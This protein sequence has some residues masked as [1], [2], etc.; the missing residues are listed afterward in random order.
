M[1]HADQEHAVQLRLS[2]LIPQL[3]DLC[4]CD[5][6]GLK[7]R[8]ALHVCLAASNK[9][10]P[11]FL[12]TL[13]KAGMIRRFTK[14][15][16]MP[17]ATSSA[18]DAQCMACAFYLLRLTLRRTLNDTLPTV[19]DE[20]FTYGHMG[21]VAAALNNHSHENFEIVM[22]VVANLLHCV[23]DRKKLRE[24]IRDLGCIP[25]L[26]KLT[27]EYPK[28]WG[29]LGN[30]A[31]SD[32]L[33]IILKDA[34]LLH[35]AET[36]GHKSP[37]IMSVVTA[38][39]HVYASCDS[40]GGHAQSFLSKHDVSIKL[41]GILDA[42]IHGNSHFRGSN[43]YWESLEEV[44]HVVKSLLR[45]EWQAE[46]MVNAGLVP[47]LIEL[48]KTKEKDEE[49]VMHACE[50]FLL[51]CNMPHLRKNLTKAGVPDAVQ[52]FVES[53]DI[54]T[55]DAAKGC[56]L[57]LGV[58]DDEA[59]TQ[60]NQALD[61]SDVGKTYDVFLSHKRTD[62]KDFAR[63]LY[64]LLVLR[65]VSAFLDFEYQEELQLETGL[66]KLVASCRNFVFVLT[67]NVLASKWCLQELEAA[68]DHNVNIILLV[69][70]GSRWQDENGVKFS[71]FPGPNIVSELPEKL[72]PIFTRKAIHHSDEYYS[73]F[74]NMLMKKVT[75][76]KPPPE[77]LGSHDN[78][79][80]PNA[81]NQ[82]AKQQHPAALPAPTLQVQ[83][84]PSAAG[85]P[86]LG[87]PS[88]PLVALGM[89]AAGH[90][91]L[92]QPSMLPAGVMPHAAIAPGAPYGG[93]TMT[94]DGGSSAV[95]S[96]LAHLHQSLDMRRDLAAVVSELQRIRQEQQQ[97]R[98][99]VMLELQHLRADMLG[100]MRKTLT[101]Q[102]PL[103]SHPLPSVSYAGYAPYPPTS[104]SHAMQS[105]HSMNAMPSP[106]YMVSA[107]MQGAGGGGFRR[108][109]S[110]GRL[111]GE[112][113]APGSVDSSQQQVN[114]QQQPLPQ[115]AAAGSLP[116]LVQGEG[117][118][119]SRGV[120]LGGAGRGRAR[121]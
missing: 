78:G 114:G 105:I 37:K 4:V 57:Q 103:A 91:Q 117:F 44:V 25:V 102:P 107:S 92:V 100:E 89:G 109:P 36:A 63:A 111:D 116:P 61:S 19:G 75:A 81:S 8:A 69:K 99:D 6:G 95:L 41:I 54:K 76:N 108:Q 26:V 14:I 15:T 94:M 58:L 7:R 50:A 90:P 35:A 93:S 31:R 33:H 3:L 22:E 119:R 120:A 27:M 62:A 86:L 85:Q 67:D 29:V 68:L 74:I 118:A 88:A 49:A 52:M 20:L 98:M 43:D 1:G 18:E 79:R 10:F 38:I 115:R 64:N 42:C 11:S 55:Q 71:P 59:A 32:S 70:E 83:Q 73:S 80:Q 66:S 45:S 46:R 17:L 51:L 82:Q 77:D 9:D 112:W 28:F 72:Q 13:V 104:F 16:S 23:A 2:G 40:Q 47:M 87:H 48:L 106:S 24:R 34:G 96:E 110:G 84:P 30:L 53:P 97:L 113:E 21:H 121:G 39:A 5:E 101:L 12:V 56:L 65:G 60:A